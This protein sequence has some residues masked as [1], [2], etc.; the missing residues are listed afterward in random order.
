MWRNDIK[1]KFIFP[2]N[3]LSRKGFELIFSYNYQHNINMKMSKQQTWTTEC[4]NYNKI[5]LQT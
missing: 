3:N 5:T 4:K 1:C 2:R